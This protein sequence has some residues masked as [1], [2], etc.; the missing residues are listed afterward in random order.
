MTA[1]GP[2]PSFMPV[3]VGVALIALAGWQVISTLLSPR[4]AA[5]VPPRPSPSLIEEAGTRRSVNRALSA[6]LAF[7]VAVA[8]VK[9]LGLLLAFALLTFF[10]VV[11][12]YRQRALK[13]VAVAV[14]SA[15]AFHLVFVTALGLKLPRGPL[16]F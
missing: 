16:G 14:L 9:P 6:W 7:A 8:L 3:G 5:H 4:A 11:A 12:M 10:L 1:D 15:L 2:G 13:G